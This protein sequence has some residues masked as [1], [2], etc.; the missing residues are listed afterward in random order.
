MQS[1]CETELCQYHYDAF[2]QLIANVLPCKP[3][4]KRFYC[5]NRLATEIQ[6]ANRYSMFQH[7]DQLLAQ[8]QSEG[9]A[10]D[11][12][13]LATDQQRSV[14]H[15]L[16][17]NHPRQPIA[18]T[19]YGHPRPGNGLLSL[20]G[21]NGERPDPVTGHYLLG[22]GYRAFNP[23]L[24]RFNS[25]DSWSPF[26][27]GGLNSYMYC[28]GDPINR[29]DS[30]GHISRRM[31]VKIIAWRRR[32]TARVAA[33][34]QFKKLM[35]LSSE[36]SPLPPLTDALENLQIAK[37]NTS[38]KKAALHKGLL[39][40]VLHAGN[41]RFETDT[42]KVQ[43][44]AQAL[45]QAFKDKRAEFV[46]SNAKLN[47]A[48]K[49]YVTELMESDFV[50]LGRLGI[51]GRAALNPRT[52]GELPPLSPTSEKLGFDFLDKMLLSA[53]DNFRQN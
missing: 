23:I 48:R 20:L 36:T 43:A 52:A 46:M 6:G 29:E 4:H 45:S 2:D 39:K 28:L 25:P 5:K 22:N 34:Q 47:T 40:V 30:N 27:K 9:D 19:P 49:R 42:P 13:L 10:P 1:P 8:Q 3:Q 17:A 11:A 24:M 53:I 33:T 12:T 44:R 21:F 35:K 18:Y 31:K 15:T 14:L 16:K 7:G 51:E 26:G 38:L 41:S 50:R 37:N 32:A